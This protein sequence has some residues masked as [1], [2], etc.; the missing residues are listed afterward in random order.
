MGNSL[1]EVTRN[2]KQLSKRGGG[3][4]IDLLWSE[5]NH[6]EMDDADQEMELRH[7]SVID[8]F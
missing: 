6:E 4:Y 3:N 5:K 1:E 2:Q 8:P 7:P